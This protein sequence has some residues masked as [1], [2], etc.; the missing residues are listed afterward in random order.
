MLLR[1]SV[2]GANTQFERFQDY[3][4]SAEIVHSPLHLFGFCFGPAT[5]LDYLEFVRLHILMSI[6]CVSFCP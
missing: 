2:S 1:Y 6:A 3:E 5:S 4:P